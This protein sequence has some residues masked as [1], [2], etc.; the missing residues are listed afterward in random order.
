MDRL[1]EIEERFIDASMSD[2]PFDAKLARK[3]HLAE[4]DVPWL[5]AEIAALRRELEE[6]DLFIDSY[7][8]AVKRGE[9]MFLE[10]HPEYRERLAL[11]GTDRLVCWLLEQLTTTQ[12]R[13]KKNMRLW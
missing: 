7:N 1:E 6:A 4:I 11:P 2:M 5:I 12:T 8:Q 10:A 13:E 9:E 3:L